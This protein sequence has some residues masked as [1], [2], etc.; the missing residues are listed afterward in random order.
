MDGLKHL[1]LKN[2][3]DILGFVD[4]LDEGILLIRDP[5]QIVMD[6]KFGVYTKKWLYLSNYKEAFVD[7]FDILL[8]N[9]ASESAIELYEESVYKQHEEQME[10]FLSDLQSSTIH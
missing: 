4:E 5:I 8:V 9:Q 1:K 7:S 3:D 2:G 6:P 10:E